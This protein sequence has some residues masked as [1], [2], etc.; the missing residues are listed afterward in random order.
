MSPSIVND[1]AC[2]KQSATAVTPTVHP[3]WM[4]DGGNQM[5]ALDSY[6]AYQ[7]NEFSEPR[8][9]HLPI[10]RKVLSPLTSDV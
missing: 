8:L 4:Q 2:I 9:T 5:Q 3:Y 10:Q 7:R 6:G 1:V